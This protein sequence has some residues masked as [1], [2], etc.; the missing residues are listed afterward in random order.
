MNPRSPTLTNL[1]GK[2]GEDHSH[3]WVLY[4]VLEH[5]AAHYGQILSLLHCMRDCGV[6]GLPEQRPGGHSRAGAVTRAVHRSLFLFTN[7]V[8]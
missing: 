4:H 3:R 8:A 7:A 6:P 1:S 5:F 2:P